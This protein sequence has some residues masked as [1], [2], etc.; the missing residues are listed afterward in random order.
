MQ[1]LF[2]LIGQLV[3]AE[4]AQVAQPR[5]PAR[6]IGI[7]EFSRYHLI[8]EPVEVE[9]EEQQMRADRGNS[10]ADPLGELSALRIGAVGAEAQLGVGHQPAQNFLDRFQPGDCLSQPLA[11]NLF[12]GAGIFGLKGLRLAHGTGQVGFDIRRVRRRV[13]I[14]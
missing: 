5:P 3:R 13:K 8:V 7:G 10:L 12:Q 14:R 4:H 6:Q 11:G 9:R 1:Q 2:D